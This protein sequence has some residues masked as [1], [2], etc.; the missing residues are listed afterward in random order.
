MSCQE[1]EMK[2]SCESAAQMCQVGNMADIA[3]QGSIKKMFIEYYAHSCPRHDVWMQILDL[4]LL[5]IQ[6]AES[7]ESDQRLI[8]RALEDARCS[9]ADKVNI[10]FLDFLLFWPDADLT[11][12]LCANDDA[13][14]FD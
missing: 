2:I 7:L 14:T 10:T 8:S 9:S 6:L 11:G 3:M 4:A 1:A 13:G 12:T 5:A